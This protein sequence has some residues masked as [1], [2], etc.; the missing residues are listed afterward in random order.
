M[1]ELM[2]C[3]NWIVAISIIPHD[4]G[5]DISSAEATV[6]C[7]IATIPPNIK[8]LDPELHCEY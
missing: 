8:K 3:V 6:K 4:K 7:L 1:F 5:F 2:F